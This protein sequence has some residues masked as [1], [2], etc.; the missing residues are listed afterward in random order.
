MDIIIVGH[1]FIC[2]P[3]I[4]WSIYMLIAVLKVV[5]DHRSKKKVLLLFRFYLEAG[6][7]VHLHNSVDFEH[8]L[9][10]E[11]LLEN[12]TLFGYSKL[13][14]INE[15]NLTAFNIWLWYRKDGFTIAKYCN[16]II[17]ALPPL[18]TVSQCIFTL[19]WVQCAQ[20]YEAVNYA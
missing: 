18:V 4:M 20:N 11:K 5:N 8:K 19:H 16:S 1:I 15:T 2:T 14:F 12:N 10:S 17:Y 9:E 13:C 3:F 7:K 6:S